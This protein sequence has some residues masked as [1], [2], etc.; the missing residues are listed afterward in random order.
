[1]FAKPLPENLRNKFSHLF[2]LTSKECAISILE[3]YQ[4]RG[5]MDVERNANFSVGSPRPD[6]ADKAEIC[7]EFE[8]PNSHAFFVGWP[9]GKGE[10]QVEGTED[11]CLFHI[12]TDHERP[13]EDMDFSRNYHQSILYPNSKGL[14][15]KGFFYPS[16]TDKKRTENRTLLKRILELIGI[17]LIKKSLDEQIK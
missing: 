6:I 13:W 12:Y 11:K 4:I 1:M 7:L 2:H 9:F 8:W 15:F 16:T 3:T 5:E 10:L 17:G 14:I